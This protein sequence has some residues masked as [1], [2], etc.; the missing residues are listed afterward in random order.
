MKR[1]DMT[2][3]LLRRQRELCMTGDSNPSDEIDFA[4]REILKKIL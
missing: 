1:P 4:T 3:S 2:T